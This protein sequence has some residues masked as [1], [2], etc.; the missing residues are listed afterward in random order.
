LGKIGELIFGCMLEPNR[1]IWRL[2]RNFFFFFFFSRN[3]ATR[4]RKKSHSFSHFEFLC[5]ATLKK[6]EKKTLDRAHNVIIRGAEGCGCPG[7]CARVSIVRAFVPF[8]FLH[9]IVVSASRVPVAT[10]W[11]GG[12]RVSW[13]AMA[14]STP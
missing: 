12:E 14:V 3:V 7:S 13:L 1:E 11:R 6:N 10:L 8:A 5:L 9:C 4:K 2:L